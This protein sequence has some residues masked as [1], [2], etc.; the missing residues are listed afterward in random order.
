[1]A[2]SFLFLGLNNIGLYIYSHICVH[3]YM[4]V[5]I[6]TLLLIYFST[7]R[8]GCLQ[9]LVTVDNAVIN[10]HILVTLWGDD[11]FEYISIR[12][13]SGSCGSSNS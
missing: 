3:M 1:M 7:G 12:G 8:I 13:I 10:M 6:H 5:Y 4:H 9:I 11:L 2:R